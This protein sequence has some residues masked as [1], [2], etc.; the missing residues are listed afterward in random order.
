VPDDR[1][2]GGGFNPLRNEADMFRVLLG[3]VAFVAAIVVIVLV[4]KAL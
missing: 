1:P 4:I 3:F 2:G